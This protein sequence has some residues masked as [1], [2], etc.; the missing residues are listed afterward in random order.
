MCKL[1][2][3]L[4][5]W[6]GRAHFAAAEKAAKA[7]AAA[8]KAAAEKFLHPTGEM[9]NWCR[10]ATAKVPKWTIRVPEARWRLGRGLLRPP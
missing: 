7:A 1:V 5:R 4:D 6:G 9:S 10:V 3:S 8:K 2:C